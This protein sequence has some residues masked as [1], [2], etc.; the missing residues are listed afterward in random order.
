MIIV[1][2]FLDGDLNLEGL[3][4]AEFVGLTRVGFRGVMALEEIK[5]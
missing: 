5:G 3:V 2:C 1:E 4:D